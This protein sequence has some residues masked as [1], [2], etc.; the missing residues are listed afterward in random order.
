[1]HDIIPGRVMR[2]AGVPQYHGMTKK[3]KKLGNLEKNVLFINKDNTTPEALKIFANVMYSIKSN[4]ATLSSSSA[5]RRQ[6]S[7]LWC[8]ECVS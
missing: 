1:M 5:S 3:I 2:P 4:V 7:F 8:S 6:P